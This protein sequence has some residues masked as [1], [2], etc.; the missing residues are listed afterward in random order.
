MERDAE[1]EQINR[2]LEILRGR[3]AIYQRIALV[4]RGVFMVLMP[5]LAIGVI[6]AAIM[7]RQFDL[8]PGILLVAAA[9]V[10]PLAIRWLILSSGLRW[11]DLVSSQARGIYDPYFF[12]PDAKPPGRTPS[13][14]ELLERQIA[15]RERRLTELGED[16]PRASR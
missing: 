6:A 7:L 15:D 9:L 11:I 12:Y 1:V 2:E 5:A 10:L 8:F 14:A 13:D 16:V 3:Y 4:T